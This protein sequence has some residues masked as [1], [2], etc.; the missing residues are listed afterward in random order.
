MRSAGGPA[1]AG[2]AVP[3]AF[4]DLLVFSAGAGGGTDDLRGQD[5]ADCD[6]GGCLDDAVAA[7]SVG[8]TPDEIALLEAPY[9]PHAVAG[10]D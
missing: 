5:V 3:D 1:E 9:V 10:H 8:L 6:A 2:G 4:E 7:L